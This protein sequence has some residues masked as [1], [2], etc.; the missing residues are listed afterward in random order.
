MTRGGHYGEY[1]A[2]DQLREAEFLTRSLG[3]WS[4]GHG[5]RQGVQK[6]KNRQQ[7]ASGPCAN[8][9]PSLHKQG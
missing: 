1:P 2:G 5:A 6:L 3:G 8:A 9:A 7:L 4:H